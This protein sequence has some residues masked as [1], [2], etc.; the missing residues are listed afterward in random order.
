MPDRSLDKGAQLSNGVI[1][2]GDASKREALLSF[3]RT[4]VPPNGA[5]SAYPPPLADIRTVVHVDDKNSHLL[6]LAA[7]FGGEGAGADEGPVSHPTT[8]SG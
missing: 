2:C 3:F 7:A 1:Y 5:P 8:R 4:P 6:D